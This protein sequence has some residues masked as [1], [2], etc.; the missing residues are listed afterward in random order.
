MSDEEN[1]AGQRRMN[2]ALID[3]LASLDGYAIGHV[4]IACIKMLAAMFI[5]K[6]APATD[7]Q[8]EGVCKQAAAMLRSE[9]KSGLTNSILLGKDHSF[10]CVGLEEEEEDGEEETAVGSS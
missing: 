8:V 5:F 9:I 1:E 10:A 6:H 7:E 4:I 2:A 3:A